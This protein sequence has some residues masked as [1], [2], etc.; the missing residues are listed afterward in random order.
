[1]QDTAATKA[2]L[3]WNALYRDVVILDPANAR[4]VAAFNLS[5]YDLAQEANR[6]ALKALLLTV[7]E[8]EDA[9]GDNLSD[10]WEEAM[11]GGDDSPGPT[12]NTDGDRSSNLMEYAHGSHAGDPGSQP[13]FTTGLVDHDGNRHS[14]ITFRRRLGYAGGLRC[15]V[16]MSETLRTW[17]G[18]P[19]AVV[20]V[21]RV[22][23]YDGTGTEIVTYRTVT[24][25]P[26]HRYLRVRCILPTTEG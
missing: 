5:T 7:A 21:G 19:S 23:P 15:I 22:N 4:P 12:G 17:S 24:A 14:T 20:E 16:E 6:T 26:R 3:S 10:F 13:S 9:D 11:F 1:M 8:L 25:V 2:T 18:G